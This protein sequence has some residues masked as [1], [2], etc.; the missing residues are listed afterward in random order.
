MRKVEWS[1]IGL[2]LFWVIV[3]IIIINFPA[4]AQDNPIT[5]CRRDGYYNP[6]RLEFHNIPLNWFVWNDA[7][8]PSWGYWAEGVAMGP[9]DGVLLADALTVDTDGYSA[10]TAVLVDYTDNWTLVGDENTPLCDAPVEP[11]P[12][13]EPVPPVV[14]QV[15]SQA[16]VSSGRTCTIK[17]PEI[18]LVCNG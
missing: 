15:V 4:R 5:V 13:P 1:T 11:T 6:I 8:A 7:T 2:A 12:T 3:I 18:I 10:G 16:V 9:E 17:Y 14:Q